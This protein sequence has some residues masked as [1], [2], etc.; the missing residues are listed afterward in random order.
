MVVPLLVLV[1]EACDLTSQ[2]DGIQQLPHGARIVKQLPLQ[3][4][5]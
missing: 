2:S 3:L 4:L 1:Q 5:R